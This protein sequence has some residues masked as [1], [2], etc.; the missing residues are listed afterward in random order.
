MIDQVVEFMELV[1]TNPLTAIV[2]FVFLFVFIVKKTG[3]IAPKFLPIA[4]IVIGVV[5][6]AIVAPATGGN[7]QGGLFDGLIAGLVAAGGKDLFAVIAAIASGKIKDWDN[8]EDLIDDG[9][10]NESNKK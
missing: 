3:V 8:L 2:V 6:G 4:A 9:K 5:V 1:H 7:W 10:L